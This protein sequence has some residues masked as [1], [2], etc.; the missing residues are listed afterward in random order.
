MLIP[1]TIL[2]QLFF[3]MAAAFAL[4][5]AAEGHVGRRK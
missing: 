1:L 5:W 3:G 4:I 2:A